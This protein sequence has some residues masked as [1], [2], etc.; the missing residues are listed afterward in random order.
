[1]RLASIK[2]DDLAIVKDG[3]LIFIGELLARE[4]ALPRGASMIDLI[5]AMN[6]RVT[7]ED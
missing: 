6:L 5:A 1:M 4:R 7:K 3:S 2:P